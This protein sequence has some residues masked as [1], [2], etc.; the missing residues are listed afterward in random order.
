MRDPDEL[1]L[2]HGAAATYPVY[3]RALD[4]RNRQAILKH[5][6][7]FCRLTIERYEHHAFDAF[8]HLYRLL[9]N[10]FRLEAERRTLDEVRSA[11]EQWME[12]FRP[13][14]APHEPE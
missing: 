3:D 6:L 13:K 12:E 8:P 5:M 1:F 14:E 10:E 4:E 11:I 9:R 7:D 2:A